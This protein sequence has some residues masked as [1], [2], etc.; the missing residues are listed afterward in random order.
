MRRWRRGGLHK[1]A[2]IPL[3]HNGQRFPMLAADIQTDLGAAPAREA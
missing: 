2:A 1:D 3:T